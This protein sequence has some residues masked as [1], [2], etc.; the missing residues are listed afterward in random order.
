MQ[1]ASLATVASVAELVARALGRSRSQDPL[2]SVV[3]GPLD[4]LVDEALPGV[5][6]QPAWWAERLGLDA[7]ERNKP[8]MVPGAFNKTAAVLCRVLPYSMTSK[9]IPKSVMDR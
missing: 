3:H 2:A 8:M 6:F 1:V 4:A 7:V 9:F 5:R